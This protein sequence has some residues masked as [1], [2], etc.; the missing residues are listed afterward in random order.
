MIWY[1][2]GLGLGQS[3]ATTRVPHEGTSVICVTVTFPTLSGPVEAL[4][5]VPSGRQS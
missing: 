2:P 3:A 5:I 1:T 4:V